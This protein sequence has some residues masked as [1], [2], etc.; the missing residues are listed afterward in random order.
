HQRFLRK[1]KRKIKKNFHKSNKK[2]TM[3][4]KLFVWFSL[5]IVILNGIVWM[6]YRFP[7]SFPVKM[8]K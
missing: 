6:N 2:R 5:F 4:K 7:F 1:H 3:T 8:V